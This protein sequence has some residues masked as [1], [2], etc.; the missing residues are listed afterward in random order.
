MKELKE[1]IQQVMINAEAHIDVNAYV[2]QTFIINPINLYS[3]CK[4]A[5]KQ[6]EETGMKH[7]KKHNQN[8]LDFVPECPI[9][10]GERMAKQKYP[11]RPSVHKD[12]PEAIEAQQHEAKTERRKRFKR[13]K[14]NPKKQIDSPEPKKKKRTKGLF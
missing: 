10:A 8:Y 11:F 6:V 9:C 7:C 12:D 5:L 13:N 14:P 1:Y 3:I 4:L 2:P